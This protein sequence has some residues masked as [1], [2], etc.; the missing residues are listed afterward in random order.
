VPPATAAPYNLGMRRLAL[1]LL[2]PAALASA[3]VAGGAL[4]GRTFDVTLRKAGD[5]RTVTD[6]IVFVGGM[7]DSKA[8]HDHGFPNA[9][10]SSTAGGGRIRFAARSASVTGGTMEWTGEVRRG[11]IEGTVDWKT[12]AGDA[13]W[14]MTGTIVE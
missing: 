6:R 5:E 12:D 9:A 14:R 7:L 1:V 10:Y 3:A 11:R 4:D 13:R 8:G 2:L